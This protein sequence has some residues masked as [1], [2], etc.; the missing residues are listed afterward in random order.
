[1]TQTGI[2]TDY[3]YHIDFDNDSRLSLGLKLGFNYYEKDL[4]GLST[5]EYDTWVALNPISTK[6]LFN[7]GVGVYYFTKNISLVHPYQNLYE[8]V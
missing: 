5:T 6:F 2:Y 3:P 7:A 4:R 1:M 8:I